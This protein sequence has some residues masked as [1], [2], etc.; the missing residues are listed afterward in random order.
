MP[1]AISSEATDPLNLSVTAPSAAV[2]SHAV[3][4]ALGPLS[5]LG[6]QAQ[7]SAAARTTDHTNKSDLNK[8]VLFTLS[9]FFFDQIL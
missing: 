3:M 5:S 2:I 8:T 7:N 1:P 9:S 6:R 4:E